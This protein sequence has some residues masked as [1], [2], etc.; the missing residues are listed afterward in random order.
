MPSASVLTPYLTRPN[1]THTL[2]L[3]TSLLSSPSTWLT[4]SLL[5]RHIDDDP[6]APILLLSL[7]HERAFHSDGLRKLGVPLQHLDRSGKYTFLGIADLPLMGG[8]AVSDVVLGAVES[9]RA[10]GDGRGLLVVIESPD[11][12]L[13]TGGGSYS[14]VMDLVL[15]VLEV[16][17]PRPASYYLLPH[18]LTYPTC[19]M[20]EHTIV[21]V[22]VDEALMR[23]EEH[24]AFVIGLGHVARRVFGLRGLETGVARD[25]S[26][27]L[28]I[29]TGGAEEGDVDGGKE[30][31]Y[32]VGDGGGV[33]VFERGEVRGR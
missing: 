14:G 30:V 25:V 32:F 13:Q 21:S 6:N 10:A 29:T 19:R 20:S 11:I 23:D 27:V 17:M 31:L 3:L 1:R 22:N 18:R 26:G 2:T 7:T 4:H 33:E 28:R 24:A 5:T 9:A 8:G 12:L 15:R 16:V